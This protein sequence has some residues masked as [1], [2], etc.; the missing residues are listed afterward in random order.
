MTLFRSSTLLLAT[1]MLALA[2]SGCDTLLGSKDN[3]TTG[4]IFEE[5]RIDP[6][7]FNEVEYV[8][9]LPFFQLGANGQPFDEPQDVYVGFDELLYAVDAAG[10]HVLDLAGRPALFVDEIAGQEL[11]HPTSVIQDRR[12]HLYITARRDTVDHF[13]EAA[14]TRG[15]LGPRLPATDLMPL[16]LAH[17]MRMEKYG[18]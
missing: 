4:E 10:L 7:L 14:C 8:P 11:R 9:F 13:G 5:G 1:V 15:G 16:A 17:A 18:A 12:L 3:D 2:A 6:T